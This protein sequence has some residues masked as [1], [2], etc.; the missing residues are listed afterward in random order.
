M[1]KLASTNNLAV[2]F[3]GLAFYG[4]QTD[5]MNLFYIF[6]GIAV[7]LLCVSHRDEVNRWERDDEIGRIER[8]RA[9]D[10]DELVRGRDQHYDELNRRI[11]E[12]ND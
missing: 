8:D 6:A 2:I 7:V 10:Y 1:F 11:D 12:R 9:S 4:Q 3:G 5:Q